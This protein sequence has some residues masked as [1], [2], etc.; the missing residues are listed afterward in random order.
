MSQS[1]SKYLHLDN[2][3]NS[4]EPLTPSEHD[5]MLFIVIHQTYELWFKQIL[6]ELKYFDH[7]LFNNEIFE[8]QSVLK[9]VLTILKTLVQQVDIL[10]TMTPLSFS[11][12][13]DRLES[14]SGFQSQQFR[15]LETYLGLKQKSTIRNPMCSHAH[16]THEVDHSPSMFDRYLECLKNHYHYE[17][18][19]DILNRD[20]SKT[21]LGDTRVED[22][23]V[24]IYRND[25]LLRSL[26][27]NFVDFDE[28]LQEWRYRHVKMV[29]RTIGM[30]TGTGGSSGVE[31]LKK[32]LSLKAFPDIW[33]ARKH[34]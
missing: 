6:H 3:L 21:Y 30:K 9:R 29:E 24:S 28:G 27:E 34:F 22:I 26:C 16:S 33:N 13:R 2:I 12:F 8:V 18:P 19:E 4:Q 17:I 32:T 7:K 20:R 23:I 10:E 5:E 1:Y 25:P 14:A 15:D 31:Y 11:A